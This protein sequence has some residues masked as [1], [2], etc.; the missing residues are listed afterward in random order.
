MKARVTFSLYFDYEVE[1]KTEIECLDKAKDMFHR[2]C[3]YNY[4]EWNIE[5][6][7]EDDE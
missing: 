6:D 7:E 2:E 3:R 5:T 1:G 4:D